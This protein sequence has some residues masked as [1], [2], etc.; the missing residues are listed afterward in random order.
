MITLT[1]ADKT[2]SDQVKWD[3][4]WNLCNMHRKGYSLDT[5]TDNDPKGNR[6]T[7]IL[8]LNKN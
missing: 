3:K 7:N 6:K 8:N 2:Y 5:K 1:M 4:A